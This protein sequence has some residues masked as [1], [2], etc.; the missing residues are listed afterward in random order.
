MGV[1]TGDPEVRV[2]VLVLNA[3]SGMFKFQLMTGKL[4][5]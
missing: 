1:V 4:L 3:N 2:T 5:L